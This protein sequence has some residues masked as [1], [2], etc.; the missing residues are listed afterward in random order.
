MLQPDAAGVLLEL[1]PYL[2]VLFPLTT[3]QR[4]SRHATDKNQ[5]N[6]ISVDQHT[7]KLLTNPF[8]AAHAKNRVISNSLLTNTIKPFTI[9]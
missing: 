9:L 6:R 8:L 5:P 1:L 4:S 7:I 3:S 2:P